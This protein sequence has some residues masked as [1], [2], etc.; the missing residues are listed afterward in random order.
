[1]P[2]KCVG[3]PF[4]GRP[5]T[6]HAQASGVAR[7]CDLIARGRDDYRELVRRRTLADPGGEGRVAMQADRPPSV[8][9]PVAESLRRLR[10]ARACENRT[11]PQ[12][13]CAGMATCRLGKGRD[14]QVS[15]SECVACVVEG[16]AAVT[17]HP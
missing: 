6:C 12:C 4:A 13:G 17:G 15:L 10:L 11:A 9:T 3:C 14:G 8:A 1:M 5:E 7:Y 16:E 2:A